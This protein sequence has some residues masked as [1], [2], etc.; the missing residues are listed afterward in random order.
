MHSNVFEKSLF[1]TKAAL[2]DQKYSKISNVV[3]YYYNL[4]MQQIIF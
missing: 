1:L 4:L 3:K 2:F